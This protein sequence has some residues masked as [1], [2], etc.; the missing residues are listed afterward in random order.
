[1]IRYQGWLVLL[2]LLTVPAVSHAQ[3]SSSEL[4][5]RW[6]QK[7]D[8]AFLKHV[9]WE[10]TL[11]SAKTRAKRDNLPIVAYFTRSYAP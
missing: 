10:R 3:V 2:L 1:M 6:K 5:K 4:E 9:T 11:E 8:A 7:Q